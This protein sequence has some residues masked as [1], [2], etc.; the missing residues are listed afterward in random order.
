MERKRKYRACLIAVLVINLVV[1]AGFIMNWYRLERKAQEQSLTKVSAD[2][3]DRRYVMPVGL[4]VGLYIH[5]KG[6]M[7]LGTGKVTNVS[8]E[9]VEPG[10]DAID[11]DN[12][13]PENDP[14]LKKAIEMVQEKM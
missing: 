9:V 11:Y 12:P 5:T 10:E 14:Q 7:V 13:N 6:V 2:V 4:P 3:A 8:D 1:L